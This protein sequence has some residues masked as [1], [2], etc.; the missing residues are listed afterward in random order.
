MSEDMMNKEGDHKIMLLKLAQEMFYK[1]LDTIAV[2]KQLF[3]NIDEDTLLDELNKHIESG[4]DKHL[5][6]ITDY[7]Y[8]DGNGK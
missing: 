8:G 6:Q 4:F 3:K 1:K 5:K 7:F 2:K